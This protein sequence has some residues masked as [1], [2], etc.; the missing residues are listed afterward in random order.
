ML[1][2][3]SIH[4]STMERLEIPKFLFTCA[5]IAVVLKGSIFARPPNLGNPLFVL[6]SP[7]VHAFS[8]RETGSDAA[9]WTTT[10]DASGQ[11]Y[12]GSNA[13]VSFDGSRW[14]TSR[15][16]STYAVRG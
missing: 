9:I 5:I 7:L 11:M 16:G 6:G 1:C 2:R 3:T 12:F 8:N 4:R 15:M 13:L 14:K 10:Q